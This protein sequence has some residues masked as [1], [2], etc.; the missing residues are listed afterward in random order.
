MYTAKEVKKFKD[1]RKV[2]GSKSCT[3]GG[4][5][6]YRVSGSS[7]PYC[8]KHRAAARIFRTPLGERI[9][10]KTSIQSAKDFRE[11]HEDSELVQF[12]LIEIKQLLTGNLE[13]HPQGRSSSE[14]LLIKELK[15]S[16]EHDTVEDIFDRVLGATMTLIDNPD[17]PAYPS[18]SPYGIIPWI[19]YAFFATGAKPQ[20][21]V[22][23]PARLDLIEKFR[24]GLFMPYLFNISRFIKKIRIDDPSYFPTKYV[25]KKAS[26]PPTSAFSN[27]THHHTYQ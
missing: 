10:S 3:I 9:E 27:F 16:Y 21:R 12:G 5:D 25:S 18:N 1:K 26:A 22:S 23:T 2:N 17:H 8:S 20:L 15:Y 13:S 4:C 14:A 7:S 24:D 11:L 6:N 19:V